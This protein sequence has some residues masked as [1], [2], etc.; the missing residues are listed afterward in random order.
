ML[1]FLWASW[2]VVSELLV[3]SGKKHRFC[4]YLTHKD[5]DDSHHLYILPTTTTWFMT[6]WPLDARCESFAFQPAPAE[7]ILK[8]SATKGL[9]AAL[10]WLWP[11]NWRL[12][13][14][15][16]CWGHFSVRTSI[17]NNKLPR[18][19]KSAGQSG[20]RGSKPG[21]DFPVSAFRA[22]LLDPLRCRPYCCSLETQLFWKRESVVR[23]GA[24]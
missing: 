3:C 24:I 20:P 21:A 18:S 8:A 16:G 7:V 9:W 1:L 14:R 23:G 17:L 6:T 4:C 22:H 10:T 13:I 15:F 11:W 5:R 12:L 2:D 19:R